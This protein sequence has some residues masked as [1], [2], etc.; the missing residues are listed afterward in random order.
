ML[1]IAEPFAIQD[2]YFEGIVLERMKNGLFR[3]KLTKEVNDAPQF[4]DIALVTD[5]S[6]IMDNMCTTARGIGLQ[7][8]GT[9]LWERPN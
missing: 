3:F 1:H 5:M 9:F 4:L 2:V 8:A 6:N 7:F